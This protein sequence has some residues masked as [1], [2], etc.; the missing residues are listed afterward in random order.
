MAPAL[1]RT[2]ADRI[3]GGLVNVPKG[4]IMEKPERIELVKADHPIPT[5]SGRRGVLRMLE[6]LKGLNQKDLVICL[7]SGGGSALMPLPAGDI[8]LNELQKTTQLLLRSGANIQ[9]INAVRKH[10]SAIKG[11]QLTRIAYPAR[12]VSMIISDVVG[13]RLDTIASGP[14]YPDSTTYADALNVLGQHGL[15]D[16]VPQKILARLRAGAEG[17]IP[18]TPKPGDECFKHA[19]FRIIASNIDALR[20]AAEVGKAHHFNPRILTTEMQG[21]AR[22]VGKWL[23]KE[24]K[25]CKEAALRPAVLLSGGETTVT[26]TGKGMGGQNQELV[27]GAVE[28]IARLENV[29]LASFSTD[30]V[31]GPTDAAGAIADSFTLERAQRLDLN[32]LTYLEENNSY[33]FFKELKDLIITE[34]TGTNVMDVAIACIG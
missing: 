17:K 19:Y 10:L 9:E 28:E 22:E 1:E 31:D 4:T 12:I 24:A 11:G 5:E 33:S 13:D 20:A 27:L 29:A 25:M 34:P 2:L 23:A 3:S 18:E 30:G 21:K 6:L 16:K 32:P 8:G 26:V 14:T 15:T 7:I